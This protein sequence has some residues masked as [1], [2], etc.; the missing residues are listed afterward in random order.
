MALFSLQANID[1]L[2]AKIEKCMENT[3]K[4]DIKIKTL[5]KQKN[6]QGAMLALQR[7]KLYETELNR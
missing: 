3:H 6:R 7:R 5:L 2:E 1:K 4:E